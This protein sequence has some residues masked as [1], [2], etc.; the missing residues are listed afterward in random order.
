VGQKTDIFFF[1]TGLETDIFF[2]CTGL[3]TD[4]FFGAAFGENSVLVEPAISLVEVLPK[5]MVEIMDSG[6]GEPLGKEVIMLANS[7]FLC[8]SS[9]HLVTLYTGSA[10]SSLLRRSRFSLAT[11]TCSLCRCSWLRL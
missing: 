1:C 3:V 10:P 11:R 6:R 9:I 5:L 8:H 7:S 2:F 4:I